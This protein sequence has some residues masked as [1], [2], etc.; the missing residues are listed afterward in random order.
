MS[1]T[2]AII[3]DLSREASL[4]HTDKGLQ[5]LQAGDPIVHVTHGGRVYRRTVTR[6][7]RVWLTD[8]EGKRFRIED[9]SGD[10]DFS[11]RSYTVGTWEELFEVMTLRS[12][13]VRAGWTPGSWVRPLTLGQLR[14]A[15]ELLDWFEQEPAEHVDFYEPFDRVGCL[16]VEGENLLALRARGRAAECALDAYR[17]LR[18]G[19]NPDETERLLRGALDDLA[20]WRRR[21]S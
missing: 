19:T 14:R 6:V 7:A 3:T 2:Q 20:T 12:R 16:P 10:G 17:E 8:S 21:T 9:G 11:G 1:A 4:P 5:R 15:A 13:L 18:A